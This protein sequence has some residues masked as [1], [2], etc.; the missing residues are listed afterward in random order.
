MWL[1]ASQRWW[2]GFVSCAL[3]GILW[4]DDLAREMEWDR[5][6]PGGP[7][8]L[9]NGQLTCR[10]CNN[11]K[12]NRSQEWAIQHLAETRGMTLGD[13]LRRYYS[14]P[15]RKA[16]QARYEASP[17]GRARQARADRKRKIMGRRRK[18]KF[19]KPGG[20]ARLL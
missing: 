17:K 16:V 11:A 7:Y 14:G 8:T 4:P 12:D 13:R 20:N 15:K 3:C 9:R 1:A 6:V 10:S 18:V 19:G 5:I 2:G